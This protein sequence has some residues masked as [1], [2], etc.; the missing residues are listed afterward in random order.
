MGDRAGT[1]PTESLLGVLAPLLDYNSIEEVRQRILAV[2]M[3]RLFVSL[4]FGNLVH[5]FYDPT[6]PEPGHEI[7]ARNVA[8]VASTASASGT[9]LLQ[10]W[11]QKNLAVTLN[12]T[13]QPAVKRIY[14]AYRNFRRFMKDTSQRKEIRHLTSL[15]AEPGLLT[16]NGLQIILLEWDMPQNRQEGKPVSIRCSPYGFSMDRHRQSDFAFVWKDSNGLYELIVYTKN[17]PPPHETHESVV[18]WS[19]FNRRDWPLIVK[20]RINEYMYKCQSNYRSLYTLQQPDP[21]YVVNA[22][23]QVTG[24][25]GSNTASIQGNTQFDSQQ[26]A[27]FVP[28]DQLTEATVIGWIPADQIASAQACVQGQI[29]SLINPPVSPEN[30]LLPWAA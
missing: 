7:D 2:C 27:V 9:N 30:T 11:S 18:R 25:D 4:N 24:V 20:D 29:D 10:G 3:P 8:D 28:Y 12:A 5:E 23:W 6:D 13:N 21:D 17:T 14:D 26:G 19:S 16:K 15:L 22:L 1:Q